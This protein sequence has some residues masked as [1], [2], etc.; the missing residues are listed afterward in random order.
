MKKMLFRKPLALILSVL[1]LLPLGG[2]T[3]FAVDT[4]AGFNLLPTSDAGLTDG[5]YWFNAAIAAKAFDEDKWLSYT[6]F[7]SEDGQTLRIYDADHFEE[8]TLS[9]PGSQYLSNWLHQVGVETR[10]G[11]RLPL[12]ESAAVEQGGEYWF[13]AARF[14]KNMHLTSVDGW[15]FWLSEDGRTIYCY[16]YEALYAVYSA[17]DVSGEVYFQSFLRQAGV[18]PF[19]GMLPIVRKMADVPLSGAYY[20]N[21]DNWIDG[22]IAKENLARTENGGAP[23]S[24]DEETAR[25]AALRTEVGNAQLWALPDGS[26]IGIQIE[27]KGLSYV[28]SATSAEND[29]VFADILAYLSLVLKDDSGVSAAFSDNDPALSGVELHVEQIQEGA[30]FELVPN[31]DISGKAV[32]NIELLK[33]GSATQPDSAVTVCI[34]IPAGFDGRRSK[35]YAISVDESSVT[36]IEAR[37]EGNG[38]VFVT[39]RL[40]FFAVTETKTAEPPTQPISVKLDTDSLNMRY[41]AT[42]TIAAAVEGGSDATVVWTSSDHKVAKVKPDGTVK[43]SFP[44]TATVTCTVTDAAGNTVSDSCEVTV[45][46]A[47]WQWI[48]VYI[49]FGWIWY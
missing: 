47:W 23:Y 44:G 31:D 17:N 5:A 41:Y 33:D 32:W 40:G 22:R 10:P 20:L 27:D 11:S 19:S 9:D 8:Y 36:E 43:A 42:A 14:M 45:Y 46:Y 6:Y 37:I 26:R 34:P 25:R 4:P 12:S 35:L 28:I 18:D 30:A 39:N 16:R 24:S 1:L 2:V 13:D 49:L 29:D 48:V 21:P 7:L 15:E 38:F 3:A